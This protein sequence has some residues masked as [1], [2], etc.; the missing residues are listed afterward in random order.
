LQPIPIEQS[1]FSQTPIRTPE[2]EQ[3]L[4]TPLMDKY[5]AKIIDITSQNNSTNLLMPVPF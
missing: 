4:F 5:F 1:D 2:K 3:L